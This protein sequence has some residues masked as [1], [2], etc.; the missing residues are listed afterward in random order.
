MAF[1]YPNL[2]S[3]SASRPRSTSNRIMAFSASR[4]SNACCQEFTVKL[5]ELGRVILHSLFNDCDK[6]GQLMIRLM[7]AHRESLLFAMS[8]KGEYMTF[9]RAMGVSKD[10]LRQIRNA[11]YWWSTII[12]QS[13]LE[14]IVKLIRRR[15]DGKVIRPCQPLAGR[16]C[17]DC[18]I[19]QRISLRSFSTGECRERW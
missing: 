2:S 5:S 19:C 18:E 7:P 1:P 14:V 15:K 4:R 3:S 10:P 9:G 16:K 12:M 6:R 8:P 11:S 17:I 13:I